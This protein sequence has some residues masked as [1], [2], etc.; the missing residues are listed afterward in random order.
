MSRFSSIVVGSSASGSPERS[1]ARASWDAPP[2]G[3]LERLDGVEEQRVERDREQRAGEDEVLAFAR[4]DTERDAEAGEDERELA[5]LSQ[6]GGHREGGV[7]RIAKGDHQQERRDRLAEHDDGEDHQHA[8]RPVDQQARIEEHPDGDEEE[9]GE[10]V[11]QRP[12]ARCS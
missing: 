3:G 2:D 9:D 12:A 5:D 1:S 4:Q 7:D 8:Q 6:A 10:G 11:A